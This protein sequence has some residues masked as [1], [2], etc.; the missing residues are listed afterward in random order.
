VL[1]VE[2]V[3]VLIQAVQVVGVVVGDLAIKIVTQ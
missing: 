1:V 3:A 2:V